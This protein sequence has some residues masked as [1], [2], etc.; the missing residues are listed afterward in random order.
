MQ[1]EERFLIGELAERAGVN[2]ETLRYYERRGLLKPARRTVSGYRVYD[3]ESAARLL[4]IKRA[5]AFGFSLEEIRDLLGMK[6]ENPR[7]CHRV[8]NMLD[9]KIKELAKRISETQRFH[10]QL[11]RYRKQC[12]VALTE[13]ESCPVILEIS[14][15]PESE[16]AR[17]CS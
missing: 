2:R 4:F 5:Q 16:K 15:P 9:G 14:H 13:G 7:S 12:G 3:R 11:A 1:D 6:P 17:N 10:R 8:M